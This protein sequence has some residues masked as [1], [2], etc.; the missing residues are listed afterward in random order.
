MT[1]GGKN[2]APQ[3]LENLLKQIRFVSN[4]M[5]YGDKQ[6]Y[7]SALITL[8]EGEIIKWAKTQGISFSN[9]ADLSQ[10]EKIR[11]MLY[12]EL[13]SVNG[14]LASYETIKKF[15]ILPNDFTIET[16]EL[17]P[18]LKVKRKVCIQKYKQY[19]DEMYA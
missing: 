19:I 14:T 5:V 4:G 1:S 18:S 11:E 9:Y 3:K 13:Q 2:I 6:K 15:K 17:T 7:L 16:G 8:N 12:G 10:N